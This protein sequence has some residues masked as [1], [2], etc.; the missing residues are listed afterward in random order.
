M[1]GAILMELI[2][3]SWSL[4][5]WH[6]DGQWFRWRW[7][8]KSRELDSSWTT[9]G[10]WVDIFHCQATNWLGFQ[11][12]RFKRRGLKTF[13]KNSQKRQMKYPSMACIRLFL[14]SNNN[15]NNINNTLSTGYI[16]RLLNIMLY[17]WYIE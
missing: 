13:S 11:A 9:A 1:N 6:W 3:K 4:S 8:S 15:D 7:P 16:R 5:T 17:L 14:V 2:T 10:S 12:C